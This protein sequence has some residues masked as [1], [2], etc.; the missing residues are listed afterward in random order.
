MAACQKHLGCSLC[1]DKDYCAAARGLVLIHPVESGVL[2]PGGETVGKRSME[3]AHKQVAVVRQLSVN[4]QQKIHFYRRVN[5]N[6]NFTGNC[7]QDIVMWI[8]IEI[9]CHFLKWQ[10]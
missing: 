8:Y 2:Q 6:S 1:C 9:K 10:N 7:L 4:L 3:A 5:L